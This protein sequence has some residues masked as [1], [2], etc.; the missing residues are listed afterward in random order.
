MHRYQCAGPGGSTVQTP[1]II[2]A[3]G[4]VTTNNGDN[5]NLGPVTLSGG[6]LTGNG[7]L[8]SNSGKFLSWALT[9]GSVTVNTAPSLMSDSGTYFPGFN[10]A[11]TTTFNVGITSGPGPDLTVA[12]NLGD[13][14]GAVQG[15]GGTDSSSLVKTGAGTMLLASSNSY[16]G[17][18]TVNNGTLLL[19]NTGSLQMSTFDASGAGS[20]SFGTLSSATFGGL[21]GVSGTLVLTNTSSF[22]IALTV[23]ANNN[24]TTFSGTLGDAGFGGTLAKVGTGTLTM[25]GNTTYSGTTS[26]SNGVLALSGSM[27][28][29]AVT[30][31]SGATLSGGSNGYIGNSTTVSGGGTLA[32]ALGNSAA[33]L[34]LAGGLTLGS[35][36][37]GYGAGNYATLN[38]TLGAS[39]I[40]PINLGSSSLQLNQ[41]GAFVNIA[42]SQPVLGNYTLMTYGGT[43]GTGQFS[44]SPTTGT[45]AIQVGRDVYSLLENPTSLQLSISGLQSPAVAYFDGAVS[46]V[47]NDLSISTSC[48]WSL[49]A[50]GTQDAGTYPGMATDA[51]MSAATLSSSNVVTSLGANFTINSL[52]VNSSAASTTISDTNTLTINALADSNTNSSGYAGNPAGNGISIAANA[53]PVTLNVPVLLGNSQTWTNSGSGA[54]TVTGSVQGTAGPGATQTLTLSDSGGGTVIGAAIS[55]GTGGGNLSLVVN[56]A[57]SSVTQLNAANTYSGT[58]TV[59]NGTLALG[60]T[61]ALQNS[62]FDASGAGTLSFGTL[63]SAVFGGLQGTATSTLTLANSNSSPITL[64]VGNN[65]SSTTFSGAER[66]RR[67]QQLHEDRHR[68]ADVGGQ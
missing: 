66:Q 54:L 8:S 60:N 68:H 16:S 40:Q 56:N 23:G 4:L 51:I 64:S 44:L 27:L 53:G 14:W 67:R 65:N 41:G 62:T 22:P 19:G 18:T 2:N 36:S 31:G 9:G 15:T 59:A 39:G 29:T 63:S 34:T 28:N 61:A 45:Q 24:N 47:W 32:L 52:N 26:V 46:S 35:A 33:P 43:N 1:L 58:T 49:D 50:A 20:L 5:N 7:L 11:P 30:V 57:S 42:T 48:N 21:Q 55:N 13:K 37:A 6:T 25:A 10:M 3:G 17:T 38:Y 12:T